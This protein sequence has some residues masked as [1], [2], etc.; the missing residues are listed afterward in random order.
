MRS[1]NKITI[2]QH[3]YRF[4]FLTK[5]KGIEIQENKTSDKFWSTQPSE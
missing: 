2:N 3:A 1:L 5:T 4:S